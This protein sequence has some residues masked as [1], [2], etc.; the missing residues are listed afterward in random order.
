[1]PTPTPLTDFAVHRDREQRRFHARRPK[2]IGDVVA[3]VVTARGYARIQSIENL[4]AAWQTAAGEALARFSRPGQLK[5]N[6]LEITVSNSTVV[7]ELTFQ[8]QHILATLRT[9]LPET[10]LRDLRFRVGA[11]K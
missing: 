4:G 2:K 11:I 8:K 10:K 3:Q 6:I 5:R 7:Q 1:M 9:Q